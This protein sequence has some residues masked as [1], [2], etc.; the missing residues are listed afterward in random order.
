MPPASPP[1]IALATHAV[2]CALLA[3]LREQ[4]LLLPPDLAQVLAEARIAL[5][6]SDA[7][8]IFGGEADKVI[9]HLADR[10]GVSDL[11]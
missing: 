7:T 9:V 2:L 4:A 6:R 3:A 1:A 8:P 5:A 10:L 11:L